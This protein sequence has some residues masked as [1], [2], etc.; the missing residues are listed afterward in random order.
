MRRGSRNWI[1]KWVILPED[2]LP[3]GVGNYS[4]CPAEEDCLPVGFGVGLRRIRS[5]AKLYQLEKQE[6]IRF[7]GKLIRS[8]TL[9]FWN[10]PEEAKVPSF[11]VQCC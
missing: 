9:L 2:S 6:D 11:T 5:L 10:V 4:Y 8:Q 1:R 3:V 7:I